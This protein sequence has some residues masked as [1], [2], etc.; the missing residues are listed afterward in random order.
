[1]Y[2]CYFYSETIFPLCFAQLQQNYYSF[3][4]ILHMIKLDDCDI[5][6]CDHLVENKRSPEHM[7][8][9]VFK[10]SVSQGSDCSRVKL[11][12]R[13]TNRHLAQLDLSKT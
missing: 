2:F 8:C 1:M 7:I 3:R 5:L 10:T 9:L 13:T 4:E 6:Q 12:G 11:M